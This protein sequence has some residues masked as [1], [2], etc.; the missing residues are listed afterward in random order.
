[1]SPHS[2]APAPAPGD[3]LPGTLYATDAIPLHLRRAY[4]REALSR[5]FAEL[6]ITV[7]DG[8]C[9][10]TLRTCRLGHVR[11]ATVDSG[12]MRVRRT[13][14]PAASGPEEHLVVTLLVRGTAR[15]G[16]D[17]RTAELGPG[18]IVICD[19][20]R[21]LRANFTTPFQTKSLVFPRRLPDL[22]EAGLR[23]ITARPV[24]PGTPLGTLLLP[25]LT[26]LVDTAE[27]YP[28]ALGDAQAR[29]VLDLLGV[30]AADRLGQE[31][32][33]TPDAAR[34]LLPRIRSFI[35]DHLADPDLTPDV[36]ARA[37]HISVRYLH[38]LFQAEDVTVS[39]WIQRRRLQRC[40]REL[41]RREAV[42][43]TIAAVAHRWG[44]TSAAHF[45]RVFRA[46]YGMTPAEWRDAAAHTPPTTRG[47]LP[48]TPPPPYRHILPS[49]RPVLTGETDRTAA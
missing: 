37:H 11:V 8:Q 10:G 20:A 2:L 34:V 43:H 5:T 14:A 44:F 48:R 16:Q 26:T 42:C 25:L 22:G 24:H 29:H 17:E 3:R 27:T 12:P 6:D 13:P 30:L 41:G 15:I 39:R 35:D 31:P 4:W 21:P 46:A 18:D 40:R 19:M 38:R 36:I 32:A 23:R 33:G 7:P 9:E 47:V 45:S 49:P 28:R 1:M